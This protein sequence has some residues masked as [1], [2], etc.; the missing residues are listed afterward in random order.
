MIHLKFFGRQEE[1]QRALNRQF[2]E[3]GTDTRR[4]L[5]AS[6]TLNTDDDPRILRALAAALIEIAGGEQEVELG[7]INPVTHQ[8]PEPGVTEFPRGALVAVKGLA[9]YEPPTAAD[10]SA[11]A[12]AFV[13]APP[14]T[15]PVPAPPAPPV[16]VPLPPTPPVAGAVELDT[17]GLPWDVRIHSGARTKIADGTWKLIR[18][19]DPAKR[20]QVEAELRS[21]LSVPASPLPLSVPG[22]V[23]TPPTATALTVDG[24]LTAVAEA[25]AAG[26]M[27]QVH[28]LEACQAA[29]LDSVAALMVRPDLVGLVAAALPEGV[30]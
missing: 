30:V 29:G 26:K 19:L 2:P 9:P 24:L 7:R 28:L 12:L 8:L 15:P 21:A 1:L 20:T 18:G 17:A 10:H 13:G 14:A 23:P 5:M 3:I 4:S 6:I 27:T 22:S 25:V 11:A 16:A